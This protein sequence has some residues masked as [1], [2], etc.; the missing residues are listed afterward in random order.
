[1]KGLAFAAAILLASLAASAQ[2]RE[3]V[4]VTIAG[5]PHAGKYQASTEKGGC[6]YGMAGPGSWGNQLS[7]PKEKDPKKLNSVQLIVP[8]AKAAAAGT[9]EFQLIVRFGALL[10]ANTAY[11]VDTRAASPKKTGSGT[12]TV[13]DRGTTGEVKISA[14]TADGVKI[15][16][17]I[18]CK[19][20]MRAGA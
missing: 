17:H 19:T 6:T 8:N 1:M 9:G 18:D 7:D 13:V 5:G 12:V 16:A 11:T 3:T 4:D 14:A 10:G 20:V 2:V 15:E